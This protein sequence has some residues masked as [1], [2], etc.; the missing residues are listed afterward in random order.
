MSL[1]Y[2]GLMYFLTFN[3]I[4]FI[5]FVCAIFIVLWFRVF[6]ISLKFIEAKI[7]RIKIE[8][9]QWDWKP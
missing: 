9:R 3:L 4:V 6:M 7:L 8:N 2:D 1:L 5:V